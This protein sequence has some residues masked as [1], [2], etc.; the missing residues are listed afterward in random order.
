MTIALAAILGLHGLVHA[1]GF[2]RSWRLGVDVRRVSPTLAGIEPDGPLIRALGLLWL[3]PVAGF[4]L[5]AIG[6][7][8][9]LPIEP[10]L[11]A[12]TLV[13]LALCITWWRDAKLGVFVDVAILLALMGTAWTAQL[14]LP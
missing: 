3:L 14:G 1:V 5:A 8:L 9:D 12:S 11:I 10:V 4:A 7:A 2:I 13:S 6:L